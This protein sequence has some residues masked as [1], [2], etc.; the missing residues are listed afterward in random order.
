VVKGDVNL[1][2]ADRF[3][4]KSIYS[5][6][7]FDEVLIR[8]PKNGSNEARKSPTTAEVGPTP[9][10]G[11]GVAKQLGRIEDM[12]APNFGQAISAYEVDALLPPGE[13]R[14]KFLETL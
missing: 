3:D 14:H 10:R 9:G 13:Q 1:G 4:E 5:R 6:I 11:R 7:R 12:P 8:R 2:G